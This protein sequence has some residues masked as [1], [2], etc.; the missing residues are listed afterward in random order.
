MAHLPIKNL[1]AE[2]PFSQSKT[3]F[4]PAPGRLGFLVTRKGRR[5]SAVPMRFASA[6]AALT[7]CDSHRAAMVYFFGESA[8][9]N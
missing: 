8:K 1:F 9:A 2:A 5:H 7:W 3:L 6:H 4:L